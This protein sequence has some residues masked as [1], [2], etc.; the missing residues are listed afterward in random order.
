LG[1]N[2]EVHYAFVEMLLHQEH[3]MEAWQHAI[4]AFKIAQHLNRP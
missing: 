4:K 3:L 2:C 1:N